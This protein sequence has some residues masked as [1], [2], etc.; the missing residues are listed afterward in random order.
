M[1]PAD[2]MPG[3]PIYGDEMSDDGYAQPGDGYPGDAYGGEY[4]TYGSGMHGYDMHSGDM[5]GDGMMGDECCDICCDDL[6]W[7]ACDVLLEN[8]S[9]F[10]GVHGFKSPTDRFG[11]VG[12]LGPRNNNGNFGFQEGINWGVPIFGRSGIGYQLGGQV[13]QSDISGDAVFDDARTQ[14]FVTTGLFYRP[15]CGPGLQGGAAIDFLHDEYFVDMDLTQIRAEVSYVGKLGNEVGFWGAF[16]AE[17]DDSLLRTTFGDTILFTE[18]IQWDVVDMYTLFYRRHFCNGSTAKVWGGFTGDGD[19][20]LGAE[21]SAPL[22]ERFAVQAG[23]NY[24]IPDTDSSTNEA[25]REVWGLSINLVWYPGYRRCCS[26]SNPYRP[27]FNVADN[28][29]MLVDQASHPQFT[30]GFFDAL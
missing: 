6:C 21:V 10:G 5:Y 2:N 1:M 4:E 3:E 14:F 12:V 11:E 17:E 28:N 22:A 26:P 24:L 9:I 13:V 8:L 16:G 23:F 7:D 30:N 20:L 27:L 25:F 15:P 19:G 29:T 18:S